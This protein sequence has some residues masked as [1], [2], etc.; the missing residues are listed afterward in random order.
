[1]GAFSLGGDF[2]PSSRRKVKTVL[3]VPCVTNVIYVDFN[4]SVLYV[5]KHKEFLEVQEAEV[6][7]WLTPD[8]VAVRLDVTGHT[9]RSWIRKYPK[10]G[11]KVGG[12][13]RIDATSVEQIAAGNLEAFAADEIKVAG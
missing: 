4:H 9:V 11:Y 10:L 13:Y 7:S 5:M 1:M 3:N 8:E 2:L 12:R 6:R